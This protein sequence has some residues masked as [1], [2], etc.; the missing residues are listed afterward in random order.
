LSSIQDI[1]G[2]SNVSGV[3]TK[4]FSTTLQGARSYAAQAAKIFGDGPFT[5]VRTNIPTSLITP[6][7]RVTVDRGI[8]T[9]AVPT[10]LLDRLSTPQVVP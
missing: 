1:G 3:E 4:Y 2:F 7:M 10:S 5:F 6:E 9:V 8:N